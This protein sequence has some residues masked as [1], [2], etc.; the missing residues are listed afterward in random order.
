MAKQLTKESLTKLKTTG[1]VAQDKVLQRDLWAIHKKEFKLEQQEDSIVDDE[2]GIE[3]ECSEY[4][5]EWK[6]LGVTIK[7]LKKPMAIVGR[8]YI[9]IETDTESFEVGGEYGAKAW[10]LAT[11]VEKTKPQ[12][13]ENALLNLLEELD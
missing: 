4:Y 13:D 11:K 3:F 8:Y 10:K 5:G 2:D 9:H 6:S 7:H 12:V 1:I